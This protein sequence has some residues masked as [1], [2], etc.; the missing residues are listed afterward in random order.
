MGRSK[1]TKC[2]RKE[3]EKS[4]ECPKPCPCTPIPEPCLE[5][6][7]AAELS[8][9]YGASTAGNLIPNTHLKGS[10]T[11]SF[12]DRAFRDPSFGSFLEPESK[13]R[14]VAFGVG[15]VNNLITD[16]ERHKLRSCEWEFTIVVPG[17]GPRLLVK[18]PKNNPL[19]QQLDI[20]DTPP[21]GYTPALPP[22]SDVII[23]A[24]TTLSK[25]MDKGV[26]I[27][28]CLNAVAAGIAQGLFKNPAIPGN[29]DLLDQL[30]DKRIKFVTSGVGYATE[31]TNSGVK[32][33]SLH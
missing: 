30:F 29:P 17:T 32:F 3:E 4:E 1:C 5:D 2:N 31:L 12:I 19:I 11:F 13:V 22:P 18:D 14:V 10:R 27:A 15:S 33:W 24:Q 21:G 26:K 28:L 9:L 16:F 8:A 25:L 6:I 7:I 20:E 23:A